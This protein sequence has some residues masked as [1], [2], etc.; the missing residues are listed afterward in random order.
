MR[1]YLLNEDKLPP[2]LPVVYS[3]YVSNQIE[4][5]SDYNEGNVNLSKWRNY[6]DGI[7]SHISNRAIAF[8]YEHTRE[9]DGTTINVYM[10]VSF[11]LVNDS[12]KVF[13]EIVWMDLK[14]E[15][16]GL[17][18]PPYLYENKHHNTKREKRT[19]HLKESELKHMINET[20]RR[21]LAER[22][23][24]RLNE[25]VGRSFRM[26]LREHLTRNR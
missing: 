21:L 26:V 15:N 17:E 10:G 12:E 4:L 24:R 23:N 16:Y 2:K 1:I 13:V 25:A 14:P 18:I 6:I 5:I 9:S 20:V 8:D 19:I 7:S 3:D 22:R 11:Y